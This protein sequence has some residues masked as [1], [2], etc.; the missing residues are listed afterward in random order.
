[1][2]S[3]GKNIFYVSYKTRYFKIWG[4]RLDAKDKEKK[5]TKAKYLS[6]FQNL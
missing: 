4:L 5:K 3:D 2:Y 6:V 1:M